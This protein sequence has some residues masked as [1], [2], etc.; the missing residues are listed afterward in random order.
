ME[1]TKFCREASLT[2]K[3]AA[4]GLEAQKFC[5]E[6]D[7]HKPHSQFYKN[8]HANDGLAFYCI[9]CMRHLFKTRY[10]KTSKKAI[11]R[12]KKENKV[13][14]QAQ[15][16]ARYLGEKFAFTPTAD[17]ITPPRPQSFAVSFD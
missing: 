12:Y 3:A 7:K 15:R 13:K 9:E 17:F 10:A 4:S 5:R 8:R 2:P 1:Q 11:A 16:R 14:I 6:C